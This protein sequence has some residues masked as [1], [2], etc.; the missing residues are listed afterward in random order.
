MSLETSNEGYSLM[1]E[2]EEGETWAEYWQRVNEYDGDTL[3]LYCQS[4]CSRYPYECLDIEELH[5]Y[6]RNAET[7]PDYVPKDFYKREDKAKC[8]GKRLTVEPDYSPYPDNILFHL[9]YA[10]FIL[11]NSVDWHKMMTWIKAQP[12][13]CD[14]SP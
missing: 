8:W 14:I 5:P 11:C 9:L 6:D 12:E 2:P 1:L 4:C 13:L 10:P 3:R 7:C